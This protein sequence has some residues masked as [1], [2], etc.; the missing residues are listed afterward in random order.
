[1]E[2]AAIVPVEVVFDIETKTCGPQRQI[3]FESHT[4][5]SLERSQSDKYPMNGMLETREPD[6][7]A[8]QVS[9]PRLCLRET[10][11]Y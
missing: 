10:R 5:V 2:W 4:E 6:L 11:Q 8:C 7:R 9:W 3:R 1:M